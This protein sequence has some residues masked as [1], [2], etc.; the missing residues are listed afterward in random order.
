MNLSSTTP[1]RV[2][3][4]GAGY[5]ADFHAKGIKALSSARLAAVCEP[6][7]RA[8]A[9]FAQ[10]W[11]IPQSFET[12]DAL[13]T[14][15]VDCVHILTPPDSHYK[16]ARAAL[17]HGVHV[18]LEKPMVTS[19][20]E[21]AELV[22]LAR[23]RR[24]YLGANHNFLFS[25]AFQT[26][27]EAVESRRLGPVDHLSIEYFLELPQLRFGPFDG[28]VT[29]N[30]RHV[31]LEAGPHL[32]SAVRELLGQPEILAVNLGREA[33]IPGGPLIPRVWR[34][35]AVVGNVPV[36]LTLN[37]APGFQQRTIRVHALFGTATA[38]LDLDVCTIDQVAPGNIDIDRYRRTRNLS[39][40][41]ALQARSTFFG[42]IVGRLKRMP[43]TNPYEASIARSIACFYKSL[44]TGAPIDSRI[45]GRTG[46][47]VIEDCENILAK[48]RFP[49]GH[50]PPI[51]PTEPDINPTVLVLGAGGFIGKELVRQLL[52]AGHSV[53]AMVRK[54]NPVLA[55]LNNGRLQIV[56]GD[57]RSTEDL[58]NAFRSIKTVY[59]L[60]YSP[61][62]S[63]ADYVENEINVTKKIID[64]SKQT[65][66]RRLIYT[67]TISSFYTGSPGTITDDTPLD[68][69]IDSR[70][71]YSRAKAKSEELLMTA[72]RDHGLPV[73]IVRPGIVIGKDGNPF[74]WGVGRFSGQTCEVWGDGKHP[75]PFVLVSDVAEALTAAMTAKDIDGLSFNLV[76]GPLLSA[77]GYLDALQSA[78]D[79]TLEI[80][81]KPIWTFFTEDSVKWI[82]KLLVRHPDGARVPSY[83]DW[84]CR[85]Q[86]REFRSDRAKALLG[87]APSEQLDTLVSKGVREPVD[88][89]L[90]A[91]R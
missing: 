54:D 76:D 17:E 38:D 21:G 61:G 65:G 53:R 45:D 36:D 90:K 63:W 43:S 66:I 47:G 3:I 32:L 91:I 72:Y 14:S 2:G 26:L 56:R 60:A 10:R 67:G 5:I 42:G 4:V 52:D 75:L 27:R 44:S 41:L 24:L 11:G 74:H 59:H 55:Q 48:C 20:Q 39:K 30:P 68:P 15:G 6:N 23:G 50:T 46:Q 19:A 37:L 80:R 35:Q 8:A 84:M 78:A 16:L 73:V 29:Q 9:A 81:N 71:N 83:S 64:V 31:L 22:E 1:F 28:W 88:E 34:I 70:D 57:V 86:R 87:W 82:L 40:Q 79:L 85:T 25:Q 33:Q 89:W 49:S 58:Q 12:I 7:K 69:N 62:K 77:N 18:F 13:L 51:V